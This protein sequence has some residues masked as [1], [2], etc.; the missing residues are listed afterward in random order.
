MATNS[1]NLKHISVNVNEGESTNKTSNQSTHAGNSKSTTTTRDTLYRGVNPNSEPLPI[2]YKFN[3]VADS[4]I[5]TWLS[6]YDP[7][8]LPTPLSDAF[9]LGPV[10]SSLGITKPI[11]W[12]ANLSC[13]FKRAY[14]TIDDPHNIYGPTLG[15]RRRIESGK[16]TYPR[17]FSKSEQDRFDKLQ[18][19]YHNQRWHNLLSVGYDP[20][21]AATMVGA[22]RENGH[23]LFSPPPLFALSPRMIVT[24]DV[25]RLNMAKILNDYLNEKAKMA[26]KE[27]LEELEREENEKSKKSN[28]KKKYKNKKKKQ[29]PR[30]AEEDLE[31][32]QF[33]GQVGGNNL[34]EKRQCPTSITQS[35][36]PQDQPTENKTLDE[37]TNPIVSPLEDQLSNQTQKPPLQRKCPDDNDIPATTPSKGQ[38]TEIFNEQDK[39]IIHQARMKKLADIAAVDST[40]SSPKTRTSTCSTSKLDLEKTLEA[41]DGPIGSYETNVIETKGSHTTGLAHTPPLVPTEEEDTPQPGYAWCCDYCKKA[42]FPTFAE[43]ALHEFKCKTRMETD[44]LDGKQNEENNCPGESNEHISI[45]LLANEKNIANSNDTSALQI[46]TKAKDRSKHT[47]QRYSVVEGGKQNQSP[48]GD[49]IN[50]F[51]FD[52]GAEDSMQVQQLQQN[53]CIPFQNQTAKNETSSNMS[54]SNMLSKEKESSKHGENRT[55]L[56]GKDKKE[57]SIILAK[58]RNKVTSTP[59]ASNI[60][61]YTLEIFESRV[62]E[63]LTQ[64]DTNGEEIQSEDCNSLSPNEPE[65]II[66]NIRSICSSSSSPEDLVTQSMK[67]VTINSHEST[68]DSLIT[69]MRPTELAVATKAEQSY[70]ALSTDQLTAQIAS[71]QGENELL[72]KSQAIERQRA[73]EAVQ[74]VQLKAYIAETARDAAEQRSARFEK[75]LVD[76]I[77]DLVSKEV[78]MRELKELI[79]TASASMPLSRQM[80]TQ[81]EGQQHSPSATSYSADMQQTFNHDFRGPLEAEHFVQNPHTCFNSNHYPIQQFTAFHGPPD[82]IDSWIDQQ[83]QSVPWVRNE[84]PRREGVLSRLRRGAGAEE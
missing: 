54:V 50:T 38:S 34:A 77:T 53:D 14:A 49:A 72:R 36:L 73:T 3:D 46:K 32:D 48:A 7:S 37:K 35:S 62:D 52:E 58:K 56:T 15:G 47:E 51:D 5:V 40:S 79:A 28:K 9:R 78:V 27:L 82:P 69:L 70:N 21:T 66:K 26:E 30:N 8:S 13:D 1:T 17:E 11:V 84:S 64:G 44:E 71:L 74:R 24:E 67:Q 55:H 61:E 68:P 16:R 23:N 42:T 80:T 22:V 39:L 33:I 45:D 19:M 25:K 57:G 10:Q 2:P 31:E 4:S 41:T 65:E 60:S 81:L 6:K 63:H 20:A 43:A 29:Q 83:P 12:L 18:D 75:L 59:T 76:A